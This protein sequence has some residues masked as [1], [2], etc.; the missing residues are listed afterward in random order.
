MSS[1]QSDERKA[2]GDERPAIDSSA[3]AVAETRSA[4][5]YFIIVQHIPTVD[6]PKLYKTSTNGEDLSLERVQSLTGTRINLRRKDLI[7]IEEVS[8]TLYH[9]VI[10]QWIR[11]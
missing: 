9:V 11:D 2:S 10:A 7:H 6:S 5:R 3:A 8:A 1:I 4:P